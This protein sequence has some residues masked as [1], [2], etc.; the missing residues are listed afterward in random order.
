VSKLV[1]DSLPDDLYRR[2]AGNDLQ[3]CAEKAILICSVDTN[4]FA[5]PAMLSYFEVVAKDVRNIRLATYKGSSTS[6][7]MRRNGR[8]TILILDARTAYYIKGAVEEL[9]AKMRCSPQNS[10]FNLHVEQVLADQTDDEFEPGAY[11]ITG[12]TCKRSTEPPLAKEMLA[13]LLD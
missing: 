5:H 10:K 13:E 3:G 6:G 12:V 9:A 2:L 8:L 4:G 11:L 7:N 1:G